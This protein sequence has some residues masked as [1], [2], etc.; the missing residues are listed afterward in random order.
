MHT[1]C[2][3]FQINAHML[4]LTLQCMSSHN[5]CKGLLLKPYS[6]LYNLIWQYHSDWS[7][8][9][10]SDQDSEQSRS[11]LSV[12]F[13]SWGSPRTSGTLNS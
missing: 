3:S 1:P 10:T 2:L 13:T 12:K 4:P 6:T 8:C 5:N 7:K 9:L 11:K